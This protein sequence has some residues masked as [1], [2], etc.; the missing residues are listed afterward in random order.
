MRVKVKK[1]KVFGGWL[2]VLDSYG[3]ETVEAKFDLLSDARAHAKYLKSCLV[4][5]ED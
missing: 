5:D 4:E 1:D 3:S 2:V